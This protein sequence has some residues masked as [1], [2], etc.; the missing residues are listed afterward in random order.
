[1][2]AVHAEADPRSSVK[3]A[4]DALVGELAGSAVRSV[5]RTGF[6]AAGL[7]L[8]L[9]L[10]AILVPIASGTLAIG[11][12]A[13]EG[14]RKVVQHA[15]GGIISAILVSEGEVVEEGDV[16]LRLDPVQ[17]GAAAGIVNYQIAALRAE[18][19]VRMAEATGER[20]ATFP[21]D[22]LAHRND[23]KVDA[24]L[25]AESS[26][27][28]ARLAL[29]R[30]REL[31][32]D[33]QLLQIGERVASAVSESA[34]QNAQ[35]RLL[36]EELEGLQTLLAKGLALKSRVL[37][38]ERSLEAANGRI[39][40]LE[41][42]S[43][44]LTAEAAET[45]ALRA[46]VGVD[47]RAQAA[48]ALRSLRA[49]LASALE[50]QLATT[51]T[52]ERTDVRAPISGIVMALNVTT[53]GGVIEPGRPLLEI[54]PQGAR[55]IVRARVGNREA[56]NVQK[57]MAATVR[58]LAGGARS[59][60]RIEGIVHSISADALIDQRTGEP[61]FEVQISIPTEEAARVSA[62]VIAPGLPAEVLIKTGSHTMFEY[63]FSPIE[64]AMFR[65]A[66]DD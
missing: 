6:V 35:A 41:A 13:V 5:R 42:E 61:Y 32:L 45:R 52:L 56:D 44:R 33:Q 51:D 20:T 16:I 3:L 31:Q 53:I 27:F 10:L 58:L 36:K 28:D 38:V 8:A 7:F 4:R 22:L 57:G 40:T 46:Q 26:A 63:L 23:P 64:H 62:D 2:T 43:R 18:E 49:E 24:I 21:A 17:A 66:R 11:H 37:A 60:P 55:L 34:S 54:V 47:R 30:S 59:P 48:E 19:A 50:R 12:V 25:T 14:E 39:A 15:G 9:L 1:V 29:A 65:S